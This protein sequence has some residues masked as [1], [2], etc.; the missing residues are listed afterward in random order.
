MRANSQKLSIC[1]LSKAL[2]I[3]PSPALYDARARSHD[4]NLSNNSVRYREAA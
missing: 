2:S 1:P 3:A 4:W